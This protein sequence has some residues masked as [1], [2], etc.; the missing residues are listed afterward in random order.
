[1]RVLKQIDRARYTASRRG[2]REAAMGIDWKPLVAVT[3][4]ALACTAPRAA[5]E[6]RQVVEVTGS[7]LPALR[8]EGISPVQVITREEIRRSG[9]GTIREVLDQVAAFTSPLSDL[10]GNGSFA[11]GATGASLRSMSK[12]STLVLL[13]SRRVAPYPLADF[14]EIFVNLDALPFEAIDRVEILKGGASAL[15][16]SDAIAGVINIITRKDWVGIQARASRQQSATSGR[17][18][19]ASLSLAGGFLLPGGNPAHVTANLEL[20]RRESAM[21][22]D[23]LRYA[24]PDV[25]S[26]SSSF[27]STSTYSWPG[28]IIGSGPLPGCQTVVASLCR[29]DR[30][31][32]FEANPLA[33][34]VNLLVNL[35]QPLA[36][37]HHLF[38]EVLAAQTRTDYVNPFQPYGKSLGSIT[39]GNPNNNTAQT[40][41]F[42]GLPA[43]HP[44][45]N[46]GVDD[47]EFR[48][49]FADGHSENSNRTFQYRALM[50]IDGQWRGFD[51][52]SA[53]GVMGGHTRS[54]NRGSWS[55]SGFHERIGNDDPSQVDPQFFNRDYRIGQVNTAVVIDR[56]FPSYGDRGD[57]RQVFLDAKLSGTVAQMAS[58]PLGLAAGMDLRHES[59]AIAP[60]Q[61]LLAGDIVGQGQ[62]ASDAGRWVGAVNGELGFPVTSALQ[63]QIAARLDKYGSTAPHL[64]PKLGLRY[65]ANPTLLLR[66]S[67]ESAFRAPNLV[68]SANS[69]K[70]SFNTGAPDPLRCPQ[71]SALAKDLVAAANALPASDPQAALLRARADTVFGSECGAG[72]ASIV[73]NNPELKPEL[74]RS[75]S[76]GLALV[77]KSN[78]KLTVDTWAIELHNQIGL[79]STGE[80]LATEVAQPPGAVNRRSL[81]NDST[82]SA[83]ERALYGVLAGP[84]DSIVGRFEN[85]LRTR[86]RGTDLIGHGRL[87]TGLG[88]LEWQ[89]DAG[90]LEEMRNWSVSRND[91]G[92]NLAGRS[93]Y[94]RWKATTGL[95]LTQGAWSHTVRAITL[96]GTSSQG[97]FTDTNLSPEG[98]ARNGFTPEQCRSAGWTR[99]D[100]SLAWAPSSAATINVSVYNVFAKP[101]P[102]GLASWL[103]GAGILP[104]TPEDGKGRMLR[105]AFTWA[106]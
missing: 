4:C 79:K 47:V 61:N 95:T 27:G 57:T 60:S 34:R 105:M 11:P 103:A 13:N 39:W 67:A 7:W 26:H 92:D 44:L 31:S 53:T 51:W 22:G 24:N 42:R 1:M 12:Q 10:G 98:C 93:G 81:G 75:Y 49:R 9:A 52:E 86:V 68:E 8:G 71:A 63:A 18:G 55:L 56:L 35:S 64:S 59:Y 106:H 99:W 77:P 94:P 30:Y 65:Q 45:N 76:M 5:D 48:Y 90:Y 2:K 91:W 46:T 73:R 88:R 20:Y 17:F 36:D 102:V 41:W 66:A 28:N 21:W 72:T 97:D 15:Y 70:F 37:G 14:S 32:R 78:W 3:C 38:A 6:D 83:A 40:F 16:G 69:T 84:L 82:F 25:V 104:P 100:Y 43:G 54:M 74:S 80:I 101:A 85:T 23:L 89:I 58:G 50:G 29:Y 96:A 19:N 33:E 62:S 87:E